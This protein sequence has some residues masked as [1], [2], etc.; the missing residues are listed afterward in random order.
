ME[1]IWGRLDLIV[2][3]T[4]LV[5]MMLL[6]ACVSSGARDVEGYALGGR[7]M[8]AWAVGLSV[9]GTFTS[10]ISFLAYPASAY[11]GN[12]NA[13]VFGLALPL[14][15]AVAVRWFIPLYRARQRLSAYEL[16]DERFGTWARCYAAAAYLLLQL[17]RVAMVLLLL[18]LA[19]APLLGWQVV[20][21]VVLVGALVIVYDVLGGLRAVIWTD[22]IQ[23]L[24]L[25]GGA[26]V[27]LVLLVGRF[28]G[29]AQT[30]IRSLPSGKL[31]LGSW[32]LLDWTTSTVWVV[33]LY[34]LTE[35][36]RNYGSDQAYVQRI[37]CTATDRQAARAIWLGALSYV[38]ASILFFAI[39][40][41]LFAH[42]HAETGLLP[43]DLR[44]EE[45]FPHFI[46]TE[47]P[48]AAA[49]LVIAAIL[50][51]GMSTVDSSLNAM[52]TVVLADL[53][54][55]LRGT[56]RARLPEVVTLRLAT[57]LGG[58]L[59]TGLA[60]AIYLFYRDGS[61]TILELWFQSAGTLG[62]GLFGLF[63]LAWLLPKTPS[64]G[65]A[66][67][68]LATI[69]VL[70]WGTFARGLPADSPWAAWQCPLERKLVG[71]SG[72]LVMLALGMAL[73]ILVSR[74]RIAPNP[75][76]RAVQADERASE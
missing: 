25:F 45:V 71:V 58:A 66:L 72:T 73:S 29:G 76:W 62:G 37:L 10:S 6:A 5:A 30:M 64:W 27:C 59:G 9:L 46:R 68:V 41:A 53:L 3:V 26:A 63:L 52:S 54:R 39:G 74:G 38:P 2:V 15:A 4:Y 31:S 18:A 19:V 49:G 69:P 36:L 34:G 13:Y 20:T 70:A 22:V 57:A 75:R 65:A 16:L 35:N 1:A 43:A 21:T 24:I 11:Q 48:A 14:A 32:S 42:Y 23:V 33:F 67:A 55:P 50:A 56:H 61:R 7:Q 12:W 40:S 44:A 51:A 47:L 17:V 28:P 8:S 60:V